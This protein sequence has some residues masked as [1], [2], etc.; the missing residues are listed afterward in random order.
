MKIPSFCKEISGKIL[1]NVKGL[2]TVPAIM[3]DILCARVESMYKC[4]KGWVLYKDGQIAEISWFDT[5]VNL[6]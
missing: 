1:E 6:Y 5:M 4:H 3:D 2:E